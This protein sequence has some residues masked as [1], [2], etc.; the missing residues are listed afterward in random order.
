MSFARLALPSI[1]L[2]S[3]SCGR[4]AL[5][6]AAPALSST[7]RAFGSS[8]PRFEIKTRYTAEHEW[9]TLDTET[10]VGTVG[11]TNYAQKSLGDVVY[12]ELPSEGS[13]VKQGGEQ[14]WR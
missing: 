3:S 13:D 11:I 8:V 6:R 12:V 2:A 14:Y 1:R 4:V 9:V 7:K 10:N 5:P